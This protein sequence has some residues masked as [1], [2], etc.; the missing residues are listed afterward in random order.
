MK[1]YLLLS[2]ILLFAFSCKKNEKIQDDGKLQNDSIIAASQLEKTG[3]ESAVDGIVFTSAED[4]EEAKTVDLQLLAKVASQLQ[5]N[6]SSIKLDK[7]SSISYND[8]IMFFV[9]TYVNPVNNEQKD[10]S[11]DRKYVFA[12]KVNGR[13]LAE[14]SDETLSHLEDEVVQASKTHIFK[15]LI[16]LNDTTPGI[17]FY[18]ELNSGGM[19][20]QYWQQKFSILTFE[21]N[22]I[23]KI[24]YNYTIG[25]GNTST[26]D[27]NTDQTET[28]AA[29]LRVSDKQ[30]NGFN[31]LV[32]SKK[33]LY[34]E[35]NMT[36]DLD[37]KAN[38]KTKEETEILQYNG[39]NYTFNT[40]DKMRFLSNPTE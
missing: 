27:G 13:I 29:G 10:I 19:Q 9:I 28:L 1:K 14:E 4:F 38:Q 22:K 26:I 16:K 37:V 17:A 18:T 32:I 24:L 30:T 36:D 21:A 3:L 6:Y 12:H 23:D 40:H 5:I 25:R 15:K 34:E 31:D 39:K 20:V 35:T 8:Y 7:T 2:G 33:F 11:V